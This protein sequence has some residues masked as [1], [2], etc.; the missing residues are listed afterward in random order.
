MSSEFKATHR[1]R[2]GVEVM[3]IMRGSDNYCYAKLP[4][5]IGGGA[6]CNPDEFAALFELIPQ[7]ET[8]EVSIPVLKH[9][10]QCF[11]DFV[12][13]GYPLGYGELKRAIEA[14]EEELKRAD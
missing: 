1:T 4:G 11:E 6:C 9:I 10:L 12:H 13:G 14:R 7:P 8:V 5:K 2:A 3:S